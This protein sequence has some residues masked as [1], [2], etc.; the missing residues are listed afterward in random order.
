MGLLSWRG[1]LG[2]PPVPLALTSD[3]SLDA[4]LLEAVGGEGA[5]NAALAEAKA[6]LAHE[7]AA[8]A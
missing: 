6:A 5:A 3:E 4:T 1:E 8:R 2:L 7:R